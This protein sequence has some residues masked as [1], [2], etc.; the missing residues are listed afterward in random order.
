MEAN[1]HLKEDGLRASL[2]FDKVLLPG[3]IGP[4]GPILC[5]WLVVVSLVGWGEGWVM[6]VVKGSKYREKEREIFVN[7]SR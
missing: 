6:V 7:S 4:A 1:L 3:Y 5:R 2:A